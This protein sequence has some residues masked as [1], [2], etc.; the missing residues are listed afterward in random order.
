[1]DNGAG[2][3]HRFLAGDE[4][5]FDEILDLYREGLIFFINR[6]VK[7]LDTA[8]DLAEDT[9]LELLLHPRRYNFKTSLKT[10]LYAI[11]RHKALNYLKCAKRHPVADMAGLSERAADEAGLPEAWV[12]RRE[13]YRALEAAMAALLPD[14]RAAIHLVYVEGLS[15]E[16]AAKVLKKS[17]KQ[18]ENLVY[19]AKKALKA[20]L[21]KEGFEL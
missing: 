13:D 2:S 17:K 4:S 10:Y 7:N 9:F 19:R 11:G 20:A 8:E 15:Y 18:V 5:A 3:Y 6:Y 12:L 21:G 16:N 1:M 14:Y